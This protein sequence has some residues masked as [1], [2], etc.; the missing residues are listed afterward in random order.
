[1]RQEG[2][3]AAGRGGACSSGLRFDTV[4]AA[5]LVIGLLWVVCRC[6][7]LGQ[8]ARGGGYNFAVCVWEPRP[9]HLRCLRAER[10]CRNRWDLHYH[11]PRPIF[12]PA[13]LPQTTKRCFREE[14]AARPCSPPARP[15]ILPQRDVGRAL[16]DPTWGCADGELDGSPA[17]Q[18][19]PHLPSSFL[20][21]CPTLVRGHRGRGGDSSARARAGS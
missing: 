11:K 2:V 14:E 13:F 19:P 15:L 3:K 7:D 16:Q 10:S 12:S 18:L 1:M 5:E 9:L 20:W 4:L 8:I 17:S 21:P 6:S